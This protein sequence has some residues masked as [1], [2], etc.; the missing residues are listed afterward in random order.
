MLL[1]VCIFSIQM[2]LLWYAI[3]DLHGYN[4]MHQNILH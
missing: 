4:H 1:A 3:Y 2:G